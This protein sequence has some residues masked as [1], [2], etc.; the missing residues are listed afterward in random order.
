[1]TELTLFRNFRNKTISPTKN[2]VINGNEINVKDILSTNVVK[3]GIPAT[4]IEMHL[5]LIKSFS[6]PSCSL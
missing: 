4:A 1:M 6:N 2:I 5:L 3:F